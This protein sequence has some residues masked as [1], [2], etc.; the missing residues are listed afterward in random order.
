MLTSTPVPISQSGD[1]P[2]GTLDPLFTGIH[3]N[4]MIVYTDKTKRIKTI[5]NNPGS[6]FSNFDKYNYFKNLKLY[7]EIGI[8]KLG[9]Q[10]YTSSLNLFHNL[11]YQV[12]K[13][14]LTK[15][16]PT[17][18]IQTITLK[19]YNQYDYNKTISEIFD[20]TIDDLN[21]SIVILKST[22]DKIDYIYIHKNIPNIKVDK[23][24]QSI[25]LNNFIGYQIEKTTEVG[26]ISHGNILNLNTGL[27]EFATLSPA[28]PTPVAT[29]S[30][31][32]PTPVATL[33][34]SERFEIREYLSAESRHNEINKI[35]REIR[36]KNISSDRAAYKKLN[37]F[38]LNF[39]NIMYEINKK[40]VPA[41]CREIN[42]FEY[43]DD[44]IYIWYKNGMGISNAV[45][46]REI[47]RQ[48]TLKK[49]NKDY[50]KKII[51]AYKGNLIL[52]NHINILK[53]DINKWRELIDN[54]DYII[55][56]IE[57]LLHRA[58]PFKRIE[59]VL[60]TDA[61][62]GMTKELLTAEFPTKDMIEKYRIIQNHVNHL[63]YTKPW[64]HLHLYQFVHHL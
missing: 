25:D 41:I 10:S 35:L 19:K 48:N 42:R 7:C 51:T 2:V 22:T 38:V 55:A 40:D 20:Y 53:N 49:F 3:T 12:V 44:Y 28:T 33:N 60:N 11:H 52:M 37:K 31:T 16:H 9:T 24:Y 30:P 26:G 57:I 47:E 15:K 36:F 13:D 63:P 58:Y 64:D 61:L 56:E 46:I 8:K 21:N 27:F 59:R 34:A 17:V 45:S 32:M 50:I 54:N 39:T 14:Y 43:K 18:E 62:F 1:S 23:L 29:L 5:D 6:N 4:Y